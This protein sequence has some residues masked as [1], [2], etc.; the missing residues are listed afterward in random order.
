MRPVLRRQV[1]QRVALAGGVV[2]QDVLAGELGDHEGVAAEPPARVGPDSRLVVAQPSQSGP[3]RL[4][5]Q[6]LAAPRDDRVPTEPLR[7]PLISTVAR[8]S[9]P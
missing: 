1:V 2:V 7:Q 4:C 5:G 8:L 6:Q 9:M 3:D